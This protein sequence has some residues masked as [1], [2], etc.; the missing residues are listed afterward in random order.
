MLRSGEEYLE[1]IRD[2]RRIYIGDERVDDATEHPAFEKIARTYAALY[3]MKADPKTRDLFAYEEDGELYS[4]YYLRPRS[5][6]DLARRTRCHTAITEW[7]YGLLGRSPDAVAGNI[8]GI[9]MK[10]EILDQEGG[11]RENLLAIYEHCRKDDIFATYAIV[12]PQ[13]ARNPEF[14]QS[15]GLDI[16]ALRATAETEHGV[17]LN[18]MKMLATAA[19]VANEVIVGNILPIAPD[20]FAES[21][22][23][24]IPFNLPG[25]TLWS[26]PPIADRAEHEF[27]APLTYRYDESDCM[28]VFK[29]VEVPWEKVVVHNN[30]ALSRDIYIQTPSHVM[31]N[32]Q[33]TVRFRAK[34]RFL[35]GLASLI[36]KATAAHEVPVV[37]ETLARLAAMEAG[38]SAMVD[39][40]LHA[41]HEIDH[42]YVLF[43]RRYM[44][45]ALHWAMENHSVVLDIVRELMG[46]G[47]FQFP[48]SIKVMRDA[49]LRA[50]FET[51]W[52]TSE[53]GAVERMKLFKLA[54][55]LIGSELASRTAS[56]EKFFV[57]P[58]FS[59]R[60]YNFINA[61]WDELEGIALGLMES[62]DVPPAFLREAAD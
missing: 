27:D 50:Q 4:M 30:P 58:A 33:S 16:P 26:R 2:G 29:D 31:A 37:R 42:G 53:G 35:V 54:W 3:D 39:A 15:R 60:N 11:Y 52:S 8:T 21:I 43:N 22:T 19:A 5:K 20:R 49:E 32:H 46:G 55:D 38:F 59:V 61:P 44:Y 36:T 62:Y 40:Q 28:L 7:S 47:I 25:L 1:S 14:Y 13:G 24:I 12:P 9:A 48:A 51:L 56:Y 18:G 57:G 41:Y 34:L 45:A 17:V 23:C 6:E 10:P